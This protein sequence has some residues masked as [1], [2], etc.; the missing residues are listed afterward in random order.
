M[1]DKDKPISFKLPVRGFCSDYKSLNVEILIYP[2]RFAM[3]RAIR[4]AY[5]KHA[6]S[7]YAKGAFCIRHCNRRHKT[8]GKL[9]FSKDNL[10]A[11]YIVHELTHLTFH[12]MTN[13]HPDGRTLLRGEEDMAMC[14]DWLFSNILRTIATIHDLRF[15]IP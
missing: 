10:R 11:Y 4:K 1:K 6:K 2:T 14:M 15:S 12:L 13:G 8:V 3:C 9:L 7:S 5:P